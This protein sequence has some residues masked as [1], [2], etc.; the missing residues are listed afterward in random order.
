MAWNPIDN[1]VDHILVMGKAS[2]GLATLEGAGDKRRYD[3]R[4][5]YGL[6]GAFIVYRGQLLARWI[7]HIRLYTPE[8]WDAW[9]AWRP[10]L[11]AV[12]T[13]RRGKALD[14]WHPHLE[15]LGVSSGVV[16]EISQPAQ[17]ADGEWTISIRM[18]QFRAPVFALAKPSASKATPVDPVD[19]K[20]EE[21]TGQVQELAR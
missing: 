5:G 7:V 4:R 13:T 18:L 3:E 17:T 6:S 19:A 11:S 2:P 16:E 14:V 8:D 9:A 20:I 1:P 12:P 21:L 15:E 10:L